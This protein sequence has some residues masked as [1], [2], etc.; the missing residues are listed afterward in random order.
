MKWHLCAVTKKKQGAQ[1]IIISLFCICGSRRRI[2]SS[3]LTRRESSFLWTHWKNLRKTS[4][5]LSE[6]QFAL[7][8]SEQFPDKSWRSWKRLCSSVEQMKTFPIGSDFVLRQSVS[9][10]SP[11]AFHAALFSQSRLPLLKFFLTPALCKA[12]RMSSGS[13]PEGTN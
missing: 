3:V 11:P 4:V 6:G 1:N 7:S 8:D 10:F 13:G 2:C 5:W 9:I 12:A